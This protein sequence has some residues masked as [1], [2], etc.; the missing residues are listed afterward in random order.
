MASTS[1]E[2]VFLLYLSSEGLLAAI[3]ERLICQRIH[4]SYFL[5]SRQSAVL[6]HAKTLEDL[7]FLR[8]GN[9]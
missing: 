4:C 2:D 7:G 8:H 5:F 9:T 3:K 1:S 6:K